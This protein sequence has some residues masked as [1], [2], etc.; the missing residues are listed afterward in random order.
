MFRIKEQGNLLLAGY[1]PGVPFDPEDRD[2]TFLRNTGVLLSDNTASHSRR[3][4][5]RLK[6]FSRRDMS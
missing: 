3:L 5:F 1:L 6:S 4:V 2:S